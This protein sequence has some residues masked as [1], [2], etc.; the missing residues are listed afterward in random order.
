MHGVAGG[1]AGGR[2]RSRSRSSTT[3]A[4]GGVLV[5]E[6]THSSSG[7]R[8][9]PLD[10]F[11]AAVGRGARARR[12]RPPRRRAALQRRRRRRA[13]A[14]GLGERSPTP[15]PSASRRGSAARSARSSPA[16]R[17]TIEQ[18][19]GGQVPPRRRAP[20]VGHRRGRDALRARP[21]RRAARRRPRA[22]E[23][24]RRGDRARSRDRRDEL[25]LDPRR[26]G[27]DRAAA[28]SA[29]SRV[30]DLRPGWLRAVTHLDIGDEDIDAGDRP[31][32]RRCSLSTPEI[33]E[34]LAA[35]LDRLVRREQRD[36]RLPS[37][38]AAVLRDGEL[39][40]ETRGRRGRRRGGSRR[41]PT[42][43]TASARSRRR[44]PRPRSCSCATRASSISRTR[45][46][47]TSRAPRTR[48]RSGGSCRTPPACSARRTT[49]RG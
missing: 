9:W 5:L 39:I 48:R 17:E 35:Q 16:R 22:R 24:A 27:P 7:G 26:A 34:R 45:S 31:R 47:G 2:R 8:I 42:R 1:C 44:S 46:T 4:P 29:G 6:N 28:P 38:A 12:R 36:K 11:R 21:P 23:A 37:I 10:E 14:V 33:P 13:R 20:P 43:S 3:S 15:S 30:G 25:R 19:V 41:R 32:C 18:R 49:T 40:W